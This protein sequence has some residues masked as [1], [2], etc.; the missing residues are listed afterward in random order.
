[1]RIFIG[2]DL[3]EAAKEY[4]SALSGKLKK[5]ITGR[6][7][8]SGNFH[9]TLKFIGDTGRNDLMRIQESVD[10]AVEGHAPFSINVLRLS[11]FH[12][13]GRHIIWAGFNPSPPLAALYA[14]ME[15][16]LAKRGFS[17][18]R[19]A[20]LPHVTLAREAV[21]EDVGMLG[22][23]LEQEIPVSE[24]TI[25]ESVRMDSGLVYLPKYKKE[26]KG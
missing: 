25:F 15:K 8:S 1:M 11:T 21:I 3:H 13:A 23:S 5:N 18:D 10:G 17:E 12:R 14:D 9:V 19:Q 22:L 24:I 16:E 4:F 6:F 20:F 2:I 26:L 7:T